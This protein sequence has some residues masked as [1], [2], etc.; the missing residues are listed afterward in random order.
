MRRLASWGLG[1]AGVLSVLLALEVL[2]RVLPVSTATL[3]G[4][5]VHPHVLGYP[6]GHVWRVATGWDLR[7]PQTLTA[8]NLGF[9]SDQDF[10]PEPGAVALIGDSFVEAS[11]LSRA[12]RP[13]AQL[14]R[15]LAGTAPVFGMGGPGSALLDYAERLAFASERLQVRRFV[16]FMEAGDIRQSL[17]GSGN[18]HAACLDRATLAPRFEH[19]PAPSFGKRLVRHSALAQY[20]FSQLKVD[21]NRLWRQA[22][23]SS[24][25][26]APHEAPK[27]T[28]ASA[29][30]LPP[31]AIRAEMVEAVTQHLFDR[32]APYPVDQLVFVVDGRRSKDAL[33]APREAASEVLRERDR[34]IELARAR[35]AIV[36][37]AE[38]VYRSHWAVSSRS[39]EVGPYDAHLNRLGIDLLMRAAAKALQ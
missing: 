28:P 22:L 34:F 24:V 18:V 7:N 5:H 17:C 35:G 9:A 8:N 25:P 30:K 11:M 16:V 39:L 26:P 36:V 12:D 38:E 13:A 10:R 14:A 15:A 6:P 27:A 19:Q 20:V 33:S 32:V 3:M 2:F 29:P 37:D 1:L 21:P 4:Y 31:P 23:A